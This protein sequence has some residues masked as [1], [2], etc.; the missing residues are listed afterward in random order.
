M[1]VLIDYFNRD[2]T[3]SNIDNIRS[4][5]TNITITSRRTKRTSLKLP[6]RFAQFYGNWVAAHFSAVVGVM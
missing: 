3:G 2:A 4:C 5:K 1:I 6:F